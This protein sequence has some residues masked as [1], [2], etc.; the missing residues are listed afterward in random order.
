VINITDR[1]STLSD[2][3]ITI[4]AKSSVDLLDW[5]RYHLTEDQLNNSITSGSLYLKR[6]SILKRVVPP[7]EI[8]KNTA[9]NYA[10]NLGSK[11]PSKHRSTVSIKYEKYDELDMSDE[12]YIKQTLDVLEE[13][14]D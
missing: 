13:S 3:N 4:K 2:L 11:I 7:G 1:D 10:L 6:N 14:K 12:E 9:N 8:F 5:K